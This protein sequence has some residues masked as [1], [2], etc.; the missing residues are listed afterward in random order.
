MDRRD[1]LKSLGAGALATAA[2]AAGC[3]NPNAT[4]AEGFALGE[5]PTDKMTYRQG[6]HGEKVS[7]LGFGFMRLPSVEEG[8]DANHS[9]SD[10]DQDRINEMTDYAIAHGLNLFDTAPRYCKARSEIALGKALSRHKRDEYLVSTKLSNQNPSLWNYKGSVEM[11]E[12]SLERLQVDYLDFYMLHCVGLP[13]RDQD[14]NP[15]EPME[16]FNRRF[17]DTGMIEFLMEQR[18]KG[19]IRNLGFSYHG[20]VKV[21]DHALSMHEQVHWD[22]V[23]IQHNYIN[24]QHAADLA[25]EAGGGDANSEYLYG[26][27]VKRDI[28]IFVMEPLLGGQLANLPD[29]AVEEFKRR[30]PEQSVASW[31]FRFAGNQPRIL[32]VLSGMTFMEHLQDNLRTMSPHKPLTPDEEKLLASI[33]DRY[34]EYPLVPCTGCQYCMPCPYGI[35]IPGIF[36]HYNKMVNEGLLLTEPDDNATSAE[37]RAYRKARREYLKNYDHAIERDRQAD[38]CIGCGRCLHECPQRINIP[39]RLAMIEKV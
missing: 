32:T 30:A 27:L 19:R 38:H 31:A 14:G 29:F 33:A 17:V 7:L 21:F 9:D 22:H 37:R 18:A 23:L 15:V 26:E 13:G 28:P 12:Q 6:T 10:L 11:F 5:V 3:K 39:A 25:E 1:F 20:D 35:D 24:W 8:K 2:M 36:A 16:A 4:S 34:V